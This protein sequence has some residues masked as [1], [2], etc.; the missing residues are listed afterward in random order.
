MPGRQVSDGALAAAADEPLNGLDRR[1]HQVVVTGGH[2]D[3][4][5]RYPMS[6]IASVPSRTDQPQKASNHEPQEYSATIAC[7]HARGINRWRFCRRRC[8]C[9]W[10]RSPAWMQRP[11]VVDSREGT[12]VTIML[13]PDWQVSSVAKASAGGYQGWRLCRRRISSKKGWRRR[14]PRSAYLPGSHEGSEAGG[15]LCLGISNLTARWTNATV[16]DIVT[17]VHGPMLTL[18]RGRREE[19][20]DPRRDTG[21]HL[22][23]PATKEDS[24][25]AVVFVPAEKATGTARSA[26]AASWSA[27][28][29]SF[30]PC[31]RQSPY[32]KVRH[33]PPP[34]FLCIS[35]APS[36]PAHAPLALEVGGWPPPSERNAVEPVC[37]RKTIS[38]VGRSVDAL[39]APCP[40]SAFAAYAKGSLEWATRS[41]NRDRL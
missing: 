24:I 7:R 32:H 9:A 18:R 21:G 29:A 22:L 33:R 17:D 19:N 23:A 31:D 41:R 15:Q 11:L 38:F 28:G 27:P 26:P 2:G 40:S 13:K 35:P 8:P 39:R 37:V 14:C 1:G 5:G 36:R 12:P 10:A 16:A 3:E 20:L 4:R 30:R 6:C 34:A 25:G